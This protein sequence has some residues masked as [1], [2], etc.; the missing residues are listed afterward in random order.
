MNVG[1][2]GQT[3]RSTRKSV[4]RGQ[5]GNNVGTMYYY[6]TLRHFTILGQENAQNMARYYAKIM[7]YTAKSRFR[8]FSSRRTPS[9]TN[10]EIDIPIKSILIDINRF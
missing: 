2:L 6:S 5:T 8:R 4:E 9:V 1:K 7:Y 10:R 3:T